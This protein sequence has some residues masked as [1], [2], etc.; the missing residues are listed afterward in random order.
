MSAN[1]EY[2]DNLLRG[3]EKSLEEADS[4]N[5]EMTLSESDEEKSKEESD[6]EAAKLESMMDDFWA[7][8][9]AE[10]QEVNTASAY[11]DE[12]QVVQSEP[13]YQEELESE[14]EPM[15]QDGLESEDE[16]MY[17]DGL[18]SADEPVYQEDLISDDEPAIKL[19]DIADTVVD[20][21]AFFEDGTQNYDEL[22]SLFIDSMKEELESG[23]D[24]NDFGFSD[25]DFLLDDEDLKFDFSEEEAFEPKVSEVMPEEVV[26]EEIAEEKAITNEDFAEAVEDEEAITETA[27]VAEEESDF[28]DGAD[29]NPREAND[30]P[31]LEK[32]TSEDPDIANLFDLLDSAEAAEKEVKEE[33]KSDL[34]IDFANM[35][36]EQEPDTQM[37]SPELELEEDVEEEIEAMVFG[38]ER[39]ERNNK[40]FQ[41]LV[42]EKEEVVDEE[43]IK[44]KKEEKEAAKAAKAEAKAAKKAAKAEAKKAKQEAKRVKKEA[45]K[46]EP[47]EPFSVKAFM[48]IALFGATIMV[49]ILVLSSIFSYQPYIANARSYFDA[50]EYK[51]AYE[52]LE[53]IEIKEKDLEFYTQVRTMEK[54]S[55]KVSAYER[56]NAANKEAEA[57]SSLIEGVALYDEKVSY[58]ETI[59]LKT[60]YQF[61]FDE[62]SGILQEEYQI[63]VEEART[64]TSKIGTK[65]YTSWIQE[66]I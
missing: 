23:L 49:C 50:R 30:E 7:K 66:H 21:D 38:E 14:D 36:G 44:K 10:E 5:S 51:K 32:M 47:K 33:T 53:G 39:K 62:L 31:D 59:G 60:E 57:L 16:S 9:E 55:S 46:A 6:N 18:E 26:E 13:M 61:V 11:S 52:E 19:E 65:E 3:F 24:V 40:L 22:D 29:G 64:I 37:H 42:Q 4:D 45:E 41:K 17:H 34:N 58:A 28:K 54:L 25:E 20:E 8:I 56:M 43:A 1:E 12:A 63:S 35:F 2:L 27:S 15:Y 48:V